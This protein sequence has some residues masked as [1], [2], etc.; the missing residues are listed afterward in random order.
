MVVVLLTAAVLLAVATALLR[1]PQWFV[2]GI[3]RHR[4]WRLRDR[5][6][7][8]VLAGRLPPHPAVLALLND[9][10]MHV[11]MSSRASVIDLLIVRR[12]WGKLS[13]SAAEQVRRSVTA[14]SL[15]GLSQAE[16]GLFEEYRRQQAQ[17][18]TEVV[19]IGSWLGIAMIIYFVGFTFLLRRRPD[20][21][22]A[23]NAATK[24]RIGQATFEAVRQSP[25]AA[26]GK[27]IC[28][29]PAGV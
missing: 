10:P 4:L 8:D 29:A 26:V 19:L 20:L 2:R 23:A 21:R 1:L 24:T 18:L 7:D 28:R 9:T 14:P 5:V 6:A 25:R 16:A 11:R 12:L 22:A 27:T 3:Y 13:P 15:H 17:L